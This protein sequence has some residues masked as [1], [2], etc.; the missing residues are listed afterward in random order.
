MFYTLIQ[1][2]KFL[3]KGIFIHFFFF[4][5]IYEYKEKKSNGYIYIILFMQQRFCHNDIISSEDLYIYIYIFIKY[6]Y[7]Y[8]N[9]TL[10]Q[11]TSRLE[12]NVHLL[13]ERLT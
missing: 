1:E 11:E 2:T 4:I 10:I 3:I 9:Y 8:I 5:K 6:I 13:S 7:T 12:K